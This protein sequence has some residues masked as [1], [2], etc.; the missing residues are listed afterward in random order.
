MTT[1]SAHGAELPK[2][3]FGTW[4]LRGD[5]GADMIR[6]AIDVG[7]RHFDTAQ[8]YENEEMVGR[9]IRDSGKRDEIFLTTKV[10]PTEYRLDDF[11]ASVLRSIDTLGTEYADLLLLHWPHPEIPM[12]ELMD[13][14]NWAR[15]N[16]FTRHIGVSNFTTDLLAE[17]TQLS[18]APLVA[19]QVEYHPFLNQSRLLTACETHGMA[20]TAYCP[21]AR[22]RVFS[23]EVIQ[24]IAETHGKSAGQVTLR[25]L[26]Q[27]KP[28]V[29]IPRTS[30]PKRVEENFG[31]FDFELTDAE[32][33]AIHGLADPKGRIVPD[34]EIRDAQGLQTEDGH[35]AAKYV[36][37]WDPVD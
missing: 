8:A 20:L 22:G 18:A 32:M 31:I 16:G 7:Y 36:P 25:W 34:A 37:D 23:S 15:E 4:E 5:A 27:Q 33:A 21:I 9:A 24:T 29:A 1:V 19:N 3:G 35:A 26:V 17:A 28:V 30:N 12:A 2:L 10:W 14:L 11:K 13:G 6:H